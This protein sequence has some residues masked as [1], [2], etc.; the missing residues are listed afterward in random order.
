MS[1]IHDQPSPR[2]FSAEDKFY[3]AV[4]VICLVLLWGLR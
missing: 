4:I 1:H 3:L 2:F